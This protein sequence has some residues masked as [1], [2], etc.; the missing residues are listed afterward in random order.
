M[1]IKL[2]YDSK[3]PMYEQIKDGIKEEILKGNLK[4][5]DR[6]PS[7]RQLAKDLDI[8][9]IT[10]KRAYLDLENEGFLSS[11]LGK[12]SFVK[13]NNLNQ[14]MDKRE[15]ELLLALN[16]SVKKCF[17]ADIEKEKIYN[18]INSVYGGEK[19]EK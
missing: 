19:F 4:N 11:T 7:M 15:K 12:G 8:S 5:G 6:L 17:E 1:N 14:A 18:E 10:T 9:M 3:K 16:E 2:S 13:M